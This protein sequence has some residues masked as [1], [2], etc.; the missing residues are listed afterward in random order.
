MILN[1]FQKQRIAALYDP[2]IKDVQGFF[3]QQHR[4]SVALASGGVGGKGIWS[5]SHTYVPEMHN[6]FIFSYLGE[7]FGFIGLLLLFITLLFLWIRIISIASKA[8]DV[9]GKMICIGVFAMLAFQ[10]VLNIGMNISLLPVIGNPLPFI[11]C[12]GSSTLT[13]YFGIGL[14]LSVNM[15]SNKSMFR[16]KP[17][18]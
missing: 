1:N 6:D 12:G 13:S 11:S 2:A 14:V 10:A 15:H 8:R 4:A 17:K 7:C 5:I 3:Y 18:R 16:E 9:L